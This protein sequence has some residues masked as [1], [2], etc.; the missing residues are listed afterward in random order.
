MANLTEFYKF[1][2]PLGINFLP[3]STA[4]PWLNKAAERVVQ[5]MTNV[6]RKFSQQENIEDTWD[7]NLHYFTLAHNKSTLVYGYAPQ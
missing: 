1:M 6:I 5:T 4:Y 3:C 2:E 7:D